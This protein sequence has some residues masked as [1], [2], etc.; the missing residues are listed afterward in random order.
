MRHAVY[1]ELPALTNWPDRRSD[2]GV[3][4]AHHPFL[5]NGL[6]ALNVARTHDTAITERSVPFVI[7]TDVRTC[8]PLVKA[9]LEGGNQK[10]ALD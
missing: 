8:L 1:V 2:A 7:D 9:L 5:L 10:S 6:P 3:T 4:A